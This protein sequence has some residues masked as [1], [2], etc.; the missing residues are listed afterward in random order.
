MLA[1]SIQT[2]APPIPLEEVNLVVNGV[3]G[4]LYDEALT[5]EEN[6]SYARE[7]CTRWGTPDA[8]ALQKGLEQIKHYNEN[9]PAEQIGYSSQE[10]ITD[11]Y[12]TEPRRTAKPYT[13]D[14]S[15]HEVGTAPAIA[16]PAST[17]G[18]YCSRIAI[19]CKCQVC[20]FLAN[21]ASP[22]MPSGG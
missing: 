2:D 11:Y 12:C 5:L 6:I 4:L 9:M 16:G 22:P 17:P 18:H 7:H 14:Q 10:L 15:L 8:A 3:L 21:T 19:D 20:C 1:E 13:I